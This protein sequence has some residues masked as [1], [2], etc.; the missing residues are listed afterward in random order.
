VQKQQYHGENNE[1]VELS[2]LRYKEQEVLETLMPH[3]IQIRQTGGPEV[4][5]WTPIEVG[6]PGSGQVRL[7]QAA[8]GLNYIDV[9]HRTGY[10]SQPLPFIPGLEGAGT[11]EAIG[12]D[13]SGLKVGDR[14]AYAGPAGGYSEMRLIEAD[15]LVRL[16]DAISIDQAAAMML[17]GMT[18]QVLIR[19]VYPVTAG[20]LILVHAAAGG[21]GLILCQWAAALGATVI[22]TVSTEAKAELAHAHGCKHTI[23]YSKQ[24]FVAEVSR[25]S[26]GEKLPVVFDSVGK[27]TFLRSVDCLRSRGL[28][29]TFGQS[30][31]PI[32]PIAP[33][34][35]SQK[36]SLFLTRPLLFHY[37]ARREE[38]EASAN[39]LFNV[40]ASGKVRIN[41]NQR[42]ALKDA[43]DAHRALEARATSG[44]TILT[45]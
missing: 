2:V 6:E 37:I 39:E 36:G 17:Q 35:L 38:L 5:N 3:A 26:G 33:V 13:V 27:D 22:G 29:V 24:D 16:P 1:L 41:V 28:M 11:V 43:A 31:G 8:V 23:L 42:F 14:V 12:E 10:Y 44:S 9:Y 25:I 15:R 34:L 4:L 30:S 32:D 7:R 20:D 21:T 45:I 18:A 40:V 19:Q